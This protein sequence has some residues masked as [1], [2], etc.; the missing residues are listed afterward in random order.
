MLTNKNFNLIVSFLGGIGIWMLLLVI[1]VI[2]DNQ[3][4][5]HRY[6]VS[7]GG[8]FG[9][10]IQ[11][12]CYGL[13]TF[14]MLQLRDQQIELNQEFR[15]LEM[16]LLPET[17]Q[18]V[19][20]PENIRDIKIQMIRMEEQGYH[21]YVINLV[22]KTCTQFRNENSTTDTCN[23]LSSQIKTSREIL[24]G[25]LEMTR[26]IIQAIPMIGFIGTIIGLTEGIRYSKGMLEINPTDKQFAL[27]EVIDSFS[28]AFGTTMVALVLSLILVRYYHIYLGKMDVFFAK[29]ET[30]IIDNLISRILKKGRIKG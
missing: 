7:L 9:G 30:Y 29:A 16:Q 14:A 19:L 18:L 13:F 17:D 20:Y 6:I 2:V 8:S 24:E 27:L 21:N 5:L 1:S 23:I 12:F 10:V 3:G 11:A 4:N 28:M 25:E 22:K 26:Y 15:G